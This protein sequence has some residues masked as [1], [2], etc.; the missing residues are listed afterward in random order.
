L[1]QRERLE[2]LRHVRVARGKARQDSAARW[3]RECGVAEVRMR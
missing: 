1:R 3:I 2:Q